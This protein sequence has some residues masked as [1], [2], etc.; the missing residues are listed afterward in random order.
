[1]SFQ[2]ILYS[3]CFRTYSN[4]GMIHSKRGVY[5]RGIR[6]QILRSTCSSEL[7]FMETGLCNGFYLHPAQF[8]NVIVND[9]KFRDLDVG[10]CPSRR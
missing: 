10:F 8:N 2:L 3:Q 5:S 6:E 1:M 9:V 4:D 7:D